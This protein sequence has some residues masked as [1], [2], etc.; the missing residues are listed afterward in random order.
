MGKILVQFV[1]YPHKAK[2]DSGGMRGIVELE[3]L[4]AIERQL[5]AGI[6]IRSFFDLIVGTRYVTLMVSPEMSAARSATV[7]LMERMWD[8]CVV[9]LLT[10]FSS[11]GGIIA[12]GIGIEGWSTQ[13]CIGHF[14]RLCDTAFTPRE[15]HKIPVLNK[16]EVINNEY[17]RY[18]AKPFEQVLQNTF[19]GQPLFGGQHNQSQCSIRTGVIATS[20]GGE[21]AVVLSNY[22]RSH[23]KD[24]LCK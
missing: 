20:E 21:R 22:N 8:H 14:E 23:E 4:K 9:G 15:L 19:T 6:P 1:R 24:A 10:C 12:L 11:T 16:L 2:R 13:T 18:K 3:V 7:H 5:P 17:A